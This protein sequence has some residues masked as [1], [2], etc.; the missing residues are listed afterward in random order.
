MF[1]KERAKGEADM[2]NAEKTVSI[3]LLGI[4]VAGCTGNIIPPTSTTQPG[5][6]AGVTLQTCPVL[7]TTPI[8]MQGCDDASPGLILTG[9]TLACG[10]DGKMHVATSSPGSG[11]TRFT[12]VLQNVSSF[13]GEIASLLPKV[14]GS[15]CPVGPN[16]SPFKVEFALTYT[17]D[18]GVEVG[19]STACMFQSKVDFTSF[20]IDQE[21]LQPFD[22]TVKDEIHKALDNA[23]INAIFVPAG[24]PSRPGRCARWHMMP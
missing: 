22:G 2:L 11:A 17:G 20:K 14:G 4:A 21:L 8:T 7:P 16:L 3:A 9:P 18:Q 6:P 12:V 13:A 23:V 24:A 15:T 1:G 5:D 19:T 10:G